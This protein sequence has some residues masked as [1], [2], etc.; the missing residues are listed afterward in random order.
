[1]GEFHKSTRTKGEGRII[2]H[3]LSEDIAHSWKELRRFYVLKVSRSLILLGHYLSWKQLAS[4]KY[5]H[6]INKK[7]ML[8]GHRE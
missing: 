4:R 6:Q 1:M 3:E 8:K 7:V 2:W 5:D